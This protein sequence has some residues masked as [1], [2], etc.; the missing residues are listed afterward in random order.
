MRSCSQHRSVIALAAVLC[1]CAA[2][3][4]LQPT[5]SSTVSDVAKVAN[6]VAPATPAVSIDDVAAPVY[7]DDDASVALPPNPLGSQRRRMSPWRRVQESVDVESSARA[8]ADHKA[9]CAGAVTDARARIAPGYRFAVFNVFEPVAALPSLSSPSTR[10]GQRRVFVALTTG[11]DRKRLCRGGAVLEA[12]VESEN[13]KVDVDFFVEVEGAPGLYEFQPYFRRAGRYTMCLAV[14]AVN[15]TISWRPTMTSLTPE[16]AGNTL[17]W[18]SQT[19]IERFN[20]ATAGAPKSCLWQSWTQR[21][22][23]AAN[24]ECGTACLAAQRQLAEQRTRGG[25]CGGSGTLDTAFGSGAWMRLPACDGNLCVGNLRDAFPPDDSVLPNFYT[26][27]FR[28]SMWWVFV[29]D[30]CTIRLYSRA[31]I[32]RIISGKWL[33][34]W[35]DSTLRQASID[36]L[37]YMLGV[38]VFAKFGFMEDRLKLPAKRRPHQFVYRAWD[39]RAK[40]PDGGSAV[41]RATLCWGGCPHQKSPQICGLQMGANNRKCILAALSGKNAT[42]PQKVEKDFPTDA[43]LPDVPSVVVA[44]HFAWRFPLYNETSFMEQV[45]DTL[46]WLDATMAARL[47]EMMSTTGSAAAPKTFC[48]VP[49]LAAKRPLLVWIG[50]ARLVYSDFESRRCYSDNVVA[51]SRRLAWKVEA[52]ISQYRRAYLGKDGA[53]CRPFRDVLYMSRQE[54]TSPMHT[55]SEFGH[56]IIHYGTTRGVCITAAMK[57]NDIRPCLRNA[58][59]DYQ[60]LHWLLNAIDPVK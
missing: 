13:D 32:W 46:A 47:D 49:E 56:H 4:L 20:N 14:S 3:I 54:L 52:Y 53:R 29:S 26:R 12:A 9:A 57:G 16:A 36:F 59:A 11:A 22:C 41:M 37:E 45:A 44:N 19:G 55:G 6:R 2:A 39:R 38:P 40:Q 33:M 35:G 31:D 60:M 51:F 21:Q 42:A 48:D 28:K 23:F 8:I 7:V 43:V 34:L 25:L 18:V 17:P 15:E 50:A 30:T 27:R 24:V 58:T 5:I 1:V 10:A